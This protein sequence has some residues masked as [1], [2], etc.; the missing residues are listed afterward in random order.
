[1]MPD[2]NCHLKRCALLCRSEMV[3]SCLAEL[4]SSVRRHVAE[5][6]NLFTIL[7]KLIVRENGG[8]ND[9]QSHCLRGR[10][11]GESIPREAIQV[12]ITLFRP[13]SVGAE[14]RPPGVVEV[15]RS[16][17]GIVTGMEAPQAIQGNDGLAVREGSGM[18]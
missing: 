4:Q 14:K 18:R 11:Y 16:P 6:A 9:G 15:R 10:P 2:A 17:A 8:Q 3:E 1:M 7:E 12:A 13:G 5:S